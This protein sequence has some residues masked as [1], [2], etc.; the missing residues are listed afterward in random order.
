MSGIYKSAGGE[1]IINGRNF[2]VILLYKILIHCF[3]FY[4]KNVENLFFGL[5]RSRDYSKKIKF[6]NYK[7]FCFLD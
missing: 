6:Q 3:I 5:Y 2:N 7:W 1:N 4:F